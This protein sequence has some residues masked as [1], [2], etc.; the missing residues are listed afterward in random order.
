MALLVLGASIMAMAPA[1]RA[2]TPP[3]I[4]TLVAIRAA[5]HNETTPRYE[6]VVFEFTGPVP[7]IAVHY[8]PQLIGDGSGLP[9]AIAGNAILQLT[10]R[11]AQAHNDQG[12]STAPGRV[13]V[14]LPNVKE[15]ARSGDFEA[16][17]TYGIGI[18]RKSEI[19]I[20]TLEGPSRIVV[21]FIRP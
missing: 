6:R 14:N 13:T 5:A 2:A 20:L 19:R 1:T 7:L 4:S 9:V 18:S 15:V 10:M 3:P 11:P 21:D 12:Q 16:V 17:V 8:V